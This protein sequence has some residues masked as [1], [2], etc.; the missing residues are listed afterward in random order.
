M[1]RE[2]KGSDVRICGEMCVLSLIYSYLAVCTFCAVRCVIIICFC[3]LFSNY[4]TFV[5]F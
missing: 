1:G 4:S 3:L 5:F 2:V